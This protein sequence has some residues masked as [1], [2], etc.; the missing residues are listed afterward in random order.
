MVTTDIHRSNQTL[1]DKL[2]HIF[3]LKRMNRVSATIRPEYFALLDHLG[4]P[5]KKLPP[6]IHVAGTNGKGSTIA[7]MRA[8]LEAAGY[9][10]HVY[11]SPHLVRFNERIVLSG[12]EICDQ[13]LELLLDE[14]MSANAGMEQ[15]F[16]EISTALALTAFT[17]TPADILLLETGLG[18]RLDST[19]VIER[20]LATVITTLS[21][22]HMEFL[23]EAIEEIAGE[24]AGIMKP[25]TPCVVAHQL[26]P[27]IMPVLQEKAFI[28][29]SNLFS[30][31][32]GWRITGPGDA[33]SKVFSVQTKDK[34][35]D[36][37]P[38]PSL[39]GAHQIRNAGTA[40][41]TLLIQNKFSIPETAF[42]Q[43]LTSTIWPARLQKIESTK[44]PTGW[45]LW[46]D[47]G[48][49]DSAAEVLAD[50]ARAWAEHD[51][52]PL[53]IVTGMMGHKDAAAF[54]RPLAPLA[55]KII[56]IPIDNG[57]S[58]EH[59]AQ[60]WRNEGAKY[61]QTNP[62]WEHGLL[63]KVTT[64]QKPGRILLTGSLY[65]AQ[66]LNDK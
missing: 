15:T 58:P 6:V 42:R 3:S 45:E 4:N 50:Q 27:E 31:N 39:L 61:V 60:I 64:G 17:R 7:F 32:N 12:K 40:I 48:H 9:K 30:E 56:C 55:S 44:L 24:K 37:L 14:V 1:Q 26:Y 52:M 49:N 16:F 2:G 29:G 57:H 13:A 53:Y 59:L 38:I 54:A 28:L 51:G 23:G 8:I 5:H 41:A 47:G 11:T 33:S 18:G 36:N 66:I 62:G 63:E 22:D 43:G 65:L 35:L 20:P 21:Y 19:N 10:V 34:V 46:L 25:Q